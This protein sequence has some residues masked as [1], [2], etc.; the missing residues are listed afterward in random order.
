ML[1]K[2]RCPP[3]T[4]NKSEHVFAGNK[5]ITRSKISECPCSPLIA[6]SLVLAFPPKATHAKNNNNNKTSVNKFFLL[7]VKQVRALVPLLPAFP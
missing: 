1:G 3:I 6:C 5:L 7:G 2:V 4:L